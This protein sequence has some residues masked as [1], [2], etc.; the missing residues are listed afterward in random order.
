MAVIA[1]ALCK[2]EF[3]TCVTAKNCS[4]AEIQV[5]ELAVIFQN[6]KGEIYIDNL[7]M[8]LTY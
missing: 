8:L 4:S 3:L 2:R 6:I 1:A 7:M 5:Q